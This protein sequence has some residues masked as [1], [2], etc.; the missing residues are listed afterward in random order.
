MLAFRDWA[1][2]NLTKEVAYITQCTSYIGETGGCD[3]STF[4][5]SDVT[6]ENIRGTENTDVL[7]LLQCS[8]AASCP[9]IRMIGFEGVVTNGTK[10]E[11]K[12][13]NVID[14]VGLQCTS[15]AEND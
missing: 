1:V 2:H 12:C 11:V 15:M 13:S 10:R 8:S 14:P 6:W 7:A 9:G 4:Q 3:T 5:I